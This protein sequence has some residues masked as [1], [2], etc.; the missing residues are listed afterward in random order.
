MHIDNKVEHAIGAG[1]GFL[2]T[3][4]LPSGEFPV[5]TSKRRDM[6]GD[7]SADPSVFPT[8]LAAHALGFVPGAA[9]LRDRAI[10]FLLDQRDRHG[11][12]RHWTRDHPH[13]AVLPPDLDDTS[14]AS[15]VLARNGV[16]GTA[17][18]QLLLSNRNSRG[19]FYTWIVPRLRWTSAAHRRVV[20]GQLPRALVLYAFFRNTSAS[21][22][23]VDAVVNANCL[24]ALGAF[25]GHE[26]VVEHLLGILRTREEISCDKW[27]DNPFVIWYFFSRALSGIAPGA[28]DMIAHRIASAAPANALE[29]ALAAAG[30]L[31]WNHLPEQDS[32]LTL[33]EGQLE[34][35][36][37]PRA[38]IYHG[39]RA[40]LP[41]GTFDEP[42][43]HT[44][45]WG[46]EALTTVFCLE[47]LA[48]WLRRHRRT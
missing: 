17:D 8:A 38:A 42:R 48:Q 23:D 45:Y 2:E 44:P 31:Y 25:S 10:R 32:I 18:S 35:G 6:I 19:L 47:V 34:T 20:A 33:L 13:F 26:A 9:A 29:T 12:W 24:F 40:R 28:G 46:S 39:G 16:S 21:P 3:N 15:A 14:C 37:W 30:L 43:P 36:A 22:D 5:F 4:Q 7:V 11:L 27:Y 41:D 1:L